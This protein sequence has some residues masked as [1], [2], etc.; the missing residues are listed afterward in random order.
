M[1]NAIVV[2]NSILY[3]MWERKKDVR[4]MKLQKLLYYTA[5]FYYKEFKKDLL[6]E[7]DNF[8]KWEYG[9]VEPDVYYD[10][11]GYRYNP[12]LK[13]QKGKLDDIYIVNQKADKEFYFV[14]DRVLDSYGDKGDIALSKMTHEHRAWKEP[15][16][17]HLISKTLIRDTF[18][19]LDYGK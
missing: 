7:T 4:P 14:L 2:A 9:P 6:C 10:F 18:E 1:H 15:D 12:I 5:G 8:Y 3:R 16:I 19:N 13:L 17:N 11:A